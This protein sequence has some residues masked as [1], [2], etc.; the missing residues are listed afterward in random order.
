MDEVLAG[1]SEVGG[2]CVSLGQLRGEGTGGDK[3]GGRESIRNRREQHPLVRS[4]ASLDPSLIP[5]AEVHF[6]PALS[7]LG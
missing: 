1:D 4:Q 2:G 7:H 3:P 6:A 5:A